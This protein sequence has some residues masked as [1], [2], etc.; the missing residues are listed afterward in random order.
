MTFPQA[1]VGQLPKTLQATDK[2]TIPAEVRACLARS[3]ALFALGG[4]TGLL[5]VGAT[6]SSTTIQ[7]L[8][9]SSTSVSWCTARMH[10]GRTAA[11]RHSP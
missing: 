7:R 9:I 8:K 6:D 2:E 4:T 3:G 11:A 5:L 1:L 10:S